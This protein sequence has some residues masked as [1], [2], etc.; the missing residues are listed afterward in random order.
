MKNA[1]LFALAGLLVFACPAA[2]AV[3]IL[4][5]FI[6]SGASEV[7]PNSSPGTGSGLVWFDTEAHLMF[8]RVN[9]SGLSGI[10]TVA[11]IHAATASP[12]SGTAGVATQVP[13]F[14]VFPSGGNAGSYSMHFN[15]WNPSSYNPSFI[16]A[17]GG[18]PFA[19]ELALANAAAAGRAYFNLHT[20]AFPGG[21]I[22][23]FLTPVRASVPDSGST[24]AMLG[25]TFLGISGL[26]RKLGTMNAEL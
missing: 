16:G 14:P 4:Y 26:C 11:H 20:N 5:N 7:P 6:L 13:S 12:G 22:R 2:Q 17:N 10:A 23:G 1:F 18:N 9:F 8:I 19:A 15:M 3:P 25:L 24:L 21:E